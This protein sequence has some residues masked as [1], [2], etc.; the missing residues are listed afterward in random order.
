[1]SWI[2]S[3]LAGLLEALLGW[4]WKRRD[5]AKAVEAANEQART[6]AHQSTL[7]DATARKVASDREQNNA[8][9]DRASA[10]AAGADGMRKQSADVAAAI[11]DANR[12][13]R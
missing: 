7:R 9:L 11:A 4:W 3:L 1:M 10:D 8:D 5:A 12:E 13:V 6:E 2:G